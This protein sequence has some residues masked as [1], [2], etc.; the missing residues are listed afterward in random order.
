MNNE[1]A[2]AMQMQQAIATQQG[3]AQ[4]FEADATNKYT[5][6][7]QGSPMNMA[8]GKISAAEYE[9]VAAGQQLQRA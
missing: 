4:G 5:F 8:G 9:G 2:A 3:A 7:A 6:P 1:R